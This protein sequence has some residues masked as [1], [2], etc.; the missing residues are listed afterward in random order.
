M[1]L[2]VRYTG[3]AP[4]DI[5][6]DVSEE[7][8]AKVYNVVVDYFLSVLP[9]VELTKYS[10]YTRETT[11]VADFA[12]KYGV[13]VD[14]PSSL[15]NFYRAMLGYTNEQRDSHPRPKLAVAK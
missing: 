4:T 3:L 13:P 14:H 9:Y 6:L 12:A 15:V 8:L 2:E 10:S 5:K 7:D 1:A 11:A